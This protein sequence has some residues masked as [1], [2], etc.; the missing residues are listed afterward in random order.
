MTEQELT[1]QVR[2]HYLSG[3]SVTQVATALGITY[4]RVRRIMCAASIELRDPS[5]RLVGKT[6]PDK[7][8]K[9]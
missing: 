4:G 8:E 7:K 3:E 9:Q 6:R 2:T 1:E 5:Q